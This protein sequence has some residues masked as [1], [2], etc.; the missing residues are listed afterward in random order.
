M[1]AP[2]IVIRNEGGLYVVTVE[3]EH[4]SYPPQSFGS[5]KVAYGT[6]GGMRLVTGWKRID[7]TEQAVTQSQQAAHRLGAE[8]G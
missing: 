1:D 4:P 8:D 5:H 2:V 3:P 6:A 7:L